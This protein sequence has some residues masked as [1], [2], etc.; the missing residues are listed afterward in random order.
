MNSRLFPETEDGSSIIPD[1][2]FS[3]KVIFPDS[4]QFDLL[5]IN[6]GII[7]NLLK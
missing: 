2:C 1:G 7:S 4:W 6:I 5:M 3:L